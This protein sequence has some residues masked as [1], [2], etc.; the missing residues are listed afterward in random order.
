MDEVTITCNASDFPKNSILRKCFLC[1]VDRKVLNLDVDV[2]NT[3]LSNELYMNLEVLEPNLAEILPLMLAYYIKYWP[4][5]QRSREYYSGKLHFKN[6][7][8]KFKQYIAIK[9]NY[10]IRNGYPAELQSNTEAAREKLSK[11]VTRGSQTDYLGTKGMS[12]CS[13]VINCASSVVNTLVFTDSE[14]N[15]SVTIPLIPDNILIKKHP[16]L[17]WPEI[18]MRDIVNWPFVTVKFISPEFCFERKNCGTYQRFLSFANMQFLPFKQEYIEEVSIIDEKTPRFCYTAKLLGRYVTEYI[19]VL[20]MLGKATHQE[21]NI[22]AILFDEFLKDIEELNMNNTMAS[23][24]SVVFNIGRN[25][26]SRTKKITKGTSMTGMKSEVHYC[27]TFIPKMETSLYYFNAVQ[28]MNAAD[29]SFVYLNEFKNKTRTNVLELYPQVIYQCDF[30]EQQWRTPMEMLL[31][32]T[33]THSME[34]N[35]ICPKCTKPL[36]V[37]NLV[38]SRWKHE[39]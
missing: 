37:A 2:L 29:V 26:Y 28:D 22:I 25:H 30:C 3:I 33:Q 36:K 12:P 39:C 38:Q 4:G 9:I 8:D 13:I 32:L 35:F 7:Y 27:E 24:T 17:K 21:I 10:A 6:W 34:P 16:P 14:E 15:I 23:N 20:E 5:W 31:H 11:H 19:N 1:L 18:T